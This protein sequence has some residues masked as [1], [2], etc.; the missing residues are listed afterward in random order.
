MPQRLP[1]GV[2]L[3]VRDEHRPEGTHLVDQAR[4][5][6]EVDPRPGRN[7]VARRIPPRDLE[8]L[9]VH[10]RP[11]LH[12][13]AAE[14]APRLG[15]DRDDDRLGGRSLLEARRDR[16]HP[17]ERLLRAPLELVE[18]GTLER[19]PAQVGGDPGEGSHLRR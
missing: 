4:E 6:V 15:A 1:T 9:V 14:G 5:V 12:D 10:G 11:D 16:Q 13:V 2:L 17:V 8:L 18:A 3:R 7:H 19:L